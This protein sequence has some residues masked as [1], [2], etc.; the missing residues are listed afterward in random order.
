MA[1]QIIANYKLDQ[2]YHQ[3]YS[4]HLACLYI[5]KTFY[6]CFQSYDETYVFHLNLAP[7]F[8]L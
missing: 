1:L 2:D 4:Q 5:M 7:R 3:L 8:E 6:D